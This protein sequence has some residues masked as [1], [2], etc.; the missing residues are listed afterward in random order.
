MASAQIC[1]DVVLCLKICNFQVMSEMCLGWF[2]FENYCQSKAGSSS[3][4]SK[5]DAAQDASLKRFHL[6][7][8]ELFSCFTIYFAH[9]HFSCSELCQSF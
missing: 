6:L 9:F 3:N 4:L 2:V 5:Q 1:F 8:S 7:C